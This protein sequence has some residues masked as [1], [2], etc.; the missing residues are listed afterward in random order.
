[1]WTSAHNLLSEEF[2]DV[3]IKFRCPVDSSYVNLLISTWLE[4][5]AVSVFVQ[6]VLCEEGVVMKALDWGAHYFGDCCLYSGHLTTY[7]GERYS[8]YRHVVNWIS[9]SNF[10]RL[11]FE[12]H[13][14][15][16]SLTSR[17]PEGNQIEIIVCTLEAQ[18]IIYIIVWMVY[19]MKYFILE[20]QISLYW[21]WNLGTYLY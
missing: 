5:C 3:R 2:S 20:F 16:I 8:D 10:R 12:V 9:F 13:Y 6:Y 21:V 11:D 4:K 15:Q 14:S 17:N 1:M 7:S 18:Y 19:D